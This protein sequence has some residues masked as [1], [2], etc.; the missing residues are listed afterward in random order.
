MELC[1]NTGNKQ[2]YMKYQMTDVLISRVRPT[3]TAKGPETLPLEEVQFSYGKIELTYT[4]TDHQTGAAKG[5]VKAYWN[6]VDNT[7]G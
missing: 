4:Q 6:L 1:R 2:P 5:E 7:G 3:G